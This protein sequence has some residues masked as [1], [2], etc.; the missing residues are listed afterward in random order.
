MPIDRV[1]AHMCY[2]LTLKIQSACA[3]TIKPN[4][5]FKH[6]HQTQNCKEAFDW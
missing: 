3:C 5:K 4:L 2:A 6:T 1:K